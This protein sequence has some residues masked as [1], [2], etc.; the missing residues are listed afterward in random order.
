VA[1]IVKVVV[2]PMILSIEREM[3]EHDTRMAGSNVCVEPPQISTG[4]RR[5]AI[6]VIA[7]F[8]R[9][10]DQTPSGLLQSRAANRATECRTHLIVVEMNHIVVSNDVCTWY[11]QS[12]KDGADLG[13]QT[14]I[15]GRAFIIDSISEIDK[16]INMLVRDLGKRVAEY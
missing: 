13:G 6:A 2:S 12:G 4:N 9:P 14:T 16:K 8:G 15:G 5:T 11:L 3:R 1:I 10:D 7:R